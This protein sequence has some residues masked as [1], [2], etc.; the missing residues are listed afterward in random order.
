MRFS[1]TQHGGKQSCPPN[2]NAVVRMDIAAFRLPSSAFTLVELLVVI[3]IIGILIAL[4]LPAVQAAREAARRMQ[5]GN[6]LKQLGLALQ[7]HESAKGYFPR[8]V[9]WESPASVTGKDAIY[10]NSRQNFHVYLLPY[11]EQT[12]LFDRIDWTASIIWADATKNRDLTGVLIPGMLCPS[13]GL[14]GTTTHV[15]APW[16]NTLSLTNYSGVFTGYQ[17][18]DLNYPKKTDTSRCK[19]AAFDADVG[20]TIS[21]FGDGTSN[22]MC[23]AESLTGPPGFLRGAFW[24]DEPAGAMVFT[25]TGPNSRQADRCNGGYFS[26]WCADM[27]EANLP[28]APGDPYATVTCAARSRHPGGVQVLMADGSVHFIGESILLDVWR[29][30]AT[31]AGGEVLP[32]ID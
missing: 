21:Q 29:G 22:T 17:I 12:A 18:G 9:T 7:S 1:P 5:C 14:G 13:D 20:T 31:I 16:G 26:S 23:I 3:T 11:E 15:P 25:E 6:N 32:P 4:L 10:W 2:S 24:E 19:R 28:S 30:M 8:G 27:P